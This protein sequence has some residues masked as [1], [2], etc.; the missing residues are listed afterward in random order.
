MWG[1]CRPGLHISI[2]AY[3]TFQDAREQIGAFIEGVYNV[4]RTHSSLGCLPPRECEQA[5]PETHGVSL[6]DP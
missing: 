2:T 3:S 4:K 1:S 5:Y 6:P